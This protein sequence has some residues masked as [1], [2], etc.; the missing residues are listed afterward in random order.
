M[1]SLLVQSLALAAAIAAFGSP[2]ENI[3][4]LVGVG[5]LIVAL[6]HASWLSLASDLRHRDYIGKLKDEFS[7]EREKIR[8]AAEKEKHN[9]VAETQRRISREAASQTARA[10]FRAGSLAAAA[11]AIG[12]LMMM[13]QLF[14]LGWVAIGTAGGGIAGYILRR[15]H[16]R[17]AKEAQVAAKRTPVVVEG[18]LIESEQAD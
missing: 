12:G 15:R 16:E 6:V 7:I 14:T 11:V 10:N 5:V 1:S 18:K 3:W 9:L 8:N 13:A 4:W 17:L 2:A